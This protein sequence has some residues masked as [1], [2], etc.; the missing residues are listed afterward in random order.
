MR[1]QLSKMLTPA[2]AKALVC[3][4]LAVTALTSTAALAQASPS[5][6]TSATRYDALGRVTGSIAPDPDGAS[7]LKFAATRTSYDAAGRPIKVETGELASWQSEAIAPANWSGFTIL[8]SAETTYD[9]FDRKIKTVAKG[10]DGVTVSLAQFSYDNRGRPDCT[11]QRMNPALFANPPAN[12]CTLG[13]QGPNG[14]DRITRSTY[15]D[16]SQ[17]LKVQKA[18][19]TPIQQDYVTYTYTQNGK[20]ASVTDANGNVAALS[21]DGHDRLK[22]W[23]FPHKTATGQTSTTDYEEYAYDANSNRLSLRKRDGSTLTYSYDALGRM[24]VKVV[25]ARA[26]LDPTHS[27]DVHYA[28]DLRGLQLEA[29]FDSLSGEG[30]SNGYDGFGRMISSTQ[31]MDGAMRQ[32]TYAHDKNGNRTRITHGDGAYFTYSYDVLNRSR[33]LRE[34]GGQYVSSIYYNN[35]GSMRLNV[36]GGGMA[37][38]YTYDPVGR[39]KRITTALPGTASDNYFNFTYSPASQV[40]SRITTN[41]AYAFTGDVNENEAY[42]VNGLNQYTSVAGSAFTH[43][44]NGNLTSDGSATYQYDIE[45]RLVKAAG[46]STANLRYDPLGRLYESDA[47]TSATRT[48][49]LYDGDA[50]VAEYNSAGTLQRRYAHG[51]GTDNPQVWY[52]G[53]NVAAASRRYLYSNWQ[54]SI[55][56][57]TDSAG[58][59]I[60]INAYDEWGSPNDSNLGRFQYTGQIWL[61]EIGM[62][63]YK[64]RIYA[65]KLGRFMQTDPIGYEDQFNLY[66]YVGNDPVGRVDPSGTRIVNEVVGDDGTPDP[67]RECLWENCFG[68]GKGKKGSRSS[69][70]IEKINAEAYAKA[71][72]DPCTNGDS[73]ACGKV[74]EDWTVETI[75]VTARVPAIRVAGGLWRL[76]GFGKRWKFS[77]AGGKTAGKWAGQMA[78]RGWT[79]R[80]INVAVRRGRKVPAPNY[81]KPA[82]GATRYIHP[83]TGRSVVIDNKTKEVLHVGGDGFR[84]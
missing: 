62:Y 67:F 5:A 54:G 11:V 15:D 10:S 52:E 58:T 24:L 34:N 49:F 42:A 28:Y 78:N 44:A 79:R 8:S 84:Y 59:A 23:N 73:G 29:R 74:N 76:L 7:A 25:P 3:L 71:G 33:L 21:Y 69:K 37:N 57:V 39:I 60:T 65:P 22:R 26:G 55:T 51:G 18:I 19:G 38:R 48:R 12:A 43:D 46:G 32:L 63:Y 40:I 2:I 1:Q 20:Q 6:Y 72:P 36:R 75:I 53:G 61:S 30:I 27:R 47:G 14:P 41:D 64:A 80:Q 31:A 16:A 70:D 13:T 66:A 68:A 50:M 45:N 81:S 77:T 83:K 4:V 82:N 35:R 9:D 17:T 56:A